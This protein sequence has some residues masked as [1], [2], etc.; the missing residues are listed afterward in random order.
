MDQKMLLLFLI[1][2]PACVGFIMLAI[3]NRVRYV[4]ETLALVTASLVTLI[5]LTLWGQK[6][7]LAIPWLGFGID[8]RLRYY[9]FSQFITVAIAGFSLLLSLYSSRFMTGHSKHNQFFGFFFISEAMALGA[10]LANNLLVMLFFWEGLLIT[11]Y[12]M[13]AIGH[14]K[15]Y[16]TAMKTFIIVGLSDLCLMLG[17]IITGVQA[18][19]LVMSDIQQLT[20]GGINGVA[21][22]L[23][24][25]GAMAKA[26]AMPFHTWMPDAAVDAPLPFMAFL[27]AALEKLLGIYLVTRVA[28]DFF[29]PDLGMRLMMMTVGAVTI[30]LAAMMALVQRD[31]K[32]LLSYGAISQVGY[33]VLG[34]G[35]GIPIGVAGGLFHMINH[36]MYKCCFFLTS[37]SVEKQAGSTD[38][39]RLGG[40]W[41]K[42]P[43]TFACFAVAS[44]SVFGIPFVGGFV[45]KEMIFEGALESGYPIFFYAAVGGAFF[46]VAAFLKLGHAVFFGKLEADHQKVT[47]SHWAMTVPMAVLAFFCILFGVAY[48]LPLDYLI[49]PSLAGLGAA[50]AE[51]HFEYHLGWLL[52]VTIGIICAAALNHWL[53]VKLSGRGVDATEHIRH[54][55]G[56]RQIYDWAEKG[57]FDPYVQ[58]KV[59]FLWM[60][61][62]LFRIDR[63]I[64]WVYQ[65]FAPA[66]ASVITSIRKVHNGLYAN[67]LSW[68]VGGLLFILIYITWFMR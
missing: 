58:S 43:L 7:E 17:I 20:T 15:A 21:F 49:K 55:P 48:Q 59:V 14:E 68:S 52:W 5:A 6:L 23:M 61:R 62:V 4:R 45:S 53:G 26:A 40:L 31:F 11:L 57:V 33:M 41:R 46:T 54:L 12:A 29:T 2:I 37:G 25:I 30:V 39:G 63:G 28:L 60:A 47:E 42:M 34:V 24:M 44:A 65:S 13:I 38:L 8:F 32:R 35:T 67:Y 51:I 56:L 1:L 3:P 10:T 19:T 36:A 9:N 27:P 64:D 50:V 22:G 18:G 16:R 66:A